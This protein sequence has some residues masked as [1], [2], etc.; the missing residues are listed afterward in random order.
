VNSLLETI[1][2][3]LERPRVV[4]QQVTRHIVG[5]YD[6]PREHIGT[7]LTGRLPALEDYEVDLVLS[8]LFTPSLRDQTVFAE[9][10]GKDP[11]PTE[12][13]PQTIQHLVG[14]PTRASLITEDGS[15]HRVT[16]SDVTIQRFVL[17]LRLEGAIPDDVFELISRLPQASDRA[18]AKAIARRAIWDH[19][20]RRELLR[21]FLLATADGFNAADAA[22]FL[23][24]TETYEPKDTPDLLRQIPH[25]QQV[26]RQEIDAP[27]AKPFF[28]ERVE[29]LHGGGRDQ[30]RQDS[31]RTSTKQ[32]E[33]EFLERLNR[34]LT[35]HGRSP[36][37]AQP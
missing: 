13:W 20:G 1:A 35:E 32:I 36:S 29:E 16:L 15:T 21:T 17:R 4:S 28:N 37:A 8:P 9:L 7:F 31:S 11:Y 2:A 5:T 30:R 6:V 24:L 12:Q 19:P 33:L 25:W 23:K 10:L 26:L 14:R 3:E 22:A 27:G 34:S 18:L